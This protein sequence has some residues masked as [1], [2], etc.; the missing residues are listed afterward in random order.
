[1]ALSEEQRRKLAAKANAQGKRSSSSDAP[2]RRVSAS[3]SSPNSQLSYNNAGKSFGGGNNKKAI[4]VLGAI[5]VLIIVLAVVLLLS[6]RNKNK[7]EEQSALSG[8]TT[9][10]S[11]P[12]DNA[13]TTPVP[14]ETTSVPIVDNSNRSLPTETPGSESASESETEAMSETESAESGDTRTAA[15]ALASAVDGMNESQQTEETTLNNESYESIVTPEIEE[16]ELLDP[17][18][19]DVLGD[20][21]AELPT[22]KA[23]GIEVLSFDREEQNG[24]VRVSKKLVDSGYDIGEHISVPLSV[25]KTYDDGTQTAR[26]TLQEL[27]ALIDEAGDANLMADGD[28][29]EIQN[30]TVEYDNTNQTA[31]TAEGETTTTVNT[32][33]VSGG[34]D[35]TGSCYRVDESVDYDFDYLVRHIQWSL[36]TNDGLTTV[37]KKQLTLA[38][39]DAPRDYILIK[40]DPGIFCQTGKINFADFKTDLEASPYFITYQRDGN[41]FTLV[42]DAEKINQGY[43]NSALSN[44]VNNAR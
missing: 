8:D 11:T 3:S 4:L 43:A 41:N 12:M 26:V 25:N 39:D 34:E 35:F 6:G 20:Q 33:N 23:F 15:E 18:L 37:S 1:M 42:T 40:M 17:I 2:V 28:E 13:T 7:T 19:R 27:V 38:E 30:P 29:N 5:V 44:A 24:Y 22:L 9:S 16:P 32:A 21:Y 14:E 10:V 31:S 36:S